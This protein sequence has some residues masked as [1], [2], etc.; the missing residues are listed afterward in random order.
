MRFRMSWPKSLRKP[1]KGPQERYKH[2]SDLADDLKRSSQIL[3]RSR[4]LS[5]SRRS[6]L[7]RSNL[8]QLIMMV[9]AVVVVAAVALTYYFGKFDLQDDTQPQQQ[10]WLA[11]LPFDNLGEAEDAYFADGITDEILTKL[12]TVPEL[13]VIARQSAFKY[14][15][16]EKSI[17][18]IGKALGVDYIL[19][20]TIRW[21]RTSEGPGQVRY[22][23]LLN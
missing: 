10:I 23:S 14:R 17:A 18:E 2:A 15:G 1:A 6:G 9:T 20:G 4:P 5:L 21:Q 8:K 12:S 13:G 7:S 22:G 16:E 19:R 11:V 3:S